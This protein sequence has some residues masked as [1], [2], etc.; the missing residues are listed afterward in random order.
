[1]TQLEVDLHPNDRA[2]LARR[3]GTGRAGLTWSFDAE[4]SLNL[5]VG[6]GRWRDDGSRLVPIGTDASGST[7]C[8]WYR[9]PGERALVV[10]VDSEGHSGVVSPD[11][12]RFF[13]AVWRGS[14]PDGVSRGDAFSV[15]LGAQYSGD[16]ESSVRER[17]AARDAWRVQLYG[18]DDDD[19]M[20]QVREVAESHGVSAG[21]ARAVA[22]LESGWQPCAADCAS[23]AEVAAEAGAM[24]DAVAWARRAWAASH[25]RVPSIGR[26]YAEVL[27]AAGEVPD[28]VEALLTRG[29]PDLLR[30]AA[31]V[32]TAR[33]DL[34]EAHTL[35]C[36]A[37][38]DTWPRLAATLDTEDPAQVRSALDGLDAVEHPG[39][40]ARLRELL[41]ALDIDDIGVLRARLA[42]AG[43]GPDAAEAHA[44]LGIALV[45]TDPAEAYKQLEA[46][47]MS[48][49][50]SSSLTSRCFA[51]LE[52]LPEP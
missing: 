16:P 36:R 15:W 13:E 46:A 42:N 38:D 29:Q 8:L 52:G 47:V 27:L 40:A 9:H 44:R 32:S 24:T 2:A 20:A 31:R 25:Q 17:L 10:R 26:V 49:P 12:D 45:D 30:L 14:V 1:M 5:L 28:R 51:L 41:T 4:F 43:D 18:H 50:A 33:G 37:D 6:H 11:L 7:V 35:R 22:M 3:D 19:R 23:L 34:S 48:L 39:W 21:F